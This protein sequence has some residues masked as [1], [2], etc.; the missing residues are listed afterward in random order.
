V[1]SVRPPNHSGN[2][3]A[4]TALANHGRSLF[5]SGGAANAAVGGLVQHALNQMDHNGDGSLNSNDLPPSLRYQ[6]LTRYDRNND[7]TVDALD[8]APLLQQQLDPNHDGRI[9]LHDF[10]DD[11]QINNL[12]AL[13]VT[14]FGDINQDGTID[15]RDL[16]AILNAMGAVSLNDLPP[17]LR[18]QLLSGLDRNGDGSISAA[19]VPLVDAINQTDT[20]DR[21][22]R[23]L[24]DGNG[25]YSIQELFVLYRALT[26]LANTRRTTPDGYVD[27]SGVPPNTQRSLIAALD[28]DGD[29]KLRPYEIAPLLDSLSAQQ[30]QTTNRALLR[31]LDRNG[32]GQ[33][34]LDDGLAP[35][36]A[37]RMRRFDHNG[38]GIITIDELSADDALEAGALLAD[39]FARAGLNPPAPPGPSRPP[40]LPSPPGT[41][42]GFRYVFEDGEMK[43][44]RTPLLPPSPPMPPM[45]Q[46]LP[47]P[48][49]DGGAVLVTL[50]CLL[51]LGALFF[52][53]A[54]I[55]VRRRRSLDRKAVID[56]A[57]MGTE[58]V[59]LYTAPLP[60][61]SPPATTNDS[62]A[63]NDAAIQA[64][65]ATS[66]TRNQGALARARAASGAPGQ[67]E[68]PLSSSS[69]V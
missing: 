14:Q 54:R 48:S 20:G 43:M 46:G 23:Q 29:G 3:L 32:D 40:H 6:L 68:S 8:F 1:P 69:T 19:D 51:G 65:A 64:A 50:L 37:A 53:I 13:H 34:S 59:S 42:P 63:L 10:L 15:N 4:N 7:G 31:V 41:P 26:L 21:L 45:P 28:T 60:L 49:S 12:A 36:L 30:Q 17:R 24:G 66:G 11:Q 2:M 47:S 44:K 22:L 57:S 52:C 9:N 58:P 16:P 33:I 38:D 25:H 61:A 56:P 62:Y 55:F 67:L 5:I 27:L 18:D 39:I 35:D